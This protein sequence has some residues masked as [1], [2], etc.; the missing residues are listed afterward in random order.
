MDQATEARRV[1]NI[2]YRVES[3]ES[4]VNELRAD[5][6]ANTEKLTI[7]GNDLKYVKQATDDL[8]R[9]LGGRVLI[10]AGG[11]AGFVTAVALVLMEVLKRGG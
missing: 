5:N 7:I 2:A 8:V 3:L 6:K 9:H 10:G 4:H 11:G 1:N